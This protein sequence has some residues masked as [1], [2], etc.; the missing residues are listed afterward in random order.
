VRERLRV[1]GEALRA[2]LAGSDHAWLLR[3][4]EDGRVYEV[5]FEV[6]TLF[7]DDARRIEECERI[8]G[9]LYHLHE[10]HPH[11]PPLAVAR[12]LQLFNTHV[13][14]PRHGPPAPPMPVLC[15]ASFQPQ[16][17]LADWVL[18][19]WDVLRWQKIATDSVMNPEAAA[20]ALEELRDPERFPIDRRSFWRAVPR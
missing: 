10:D 1:E 9:V 11:R 18:A 4:S 20:Y 19:T 3:A 8:V 17:R 6:R 15:L 2:T 7:Q 13:A 14:D 16:H 12:E 5:E